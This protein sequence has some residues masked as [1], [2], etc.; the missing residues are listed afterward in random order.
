MKRIG[1]I[2]D[3]NLPT[4]DNSVKEK[5]FDWALS[6]A[7]RQ[8]LDCII[9]AG[10]LT[11]C[12]SAAAAE[13]VWKKLENC[14][15]PFALTLGNADLRDSSEREKARTFLKT[16]ND[17]PG[18]CL[19][20]T[21]RR[22]LSPADTA[23]LRNIAPGT[24]VVTHCPQECLPSETQELFRQ[25]LTSGR[26]ALLISGHF[27]ID[28]QEGNCHLIRGLDPD[29]AAGSPPALAIFTN[30]N[31]KWERENHACPVADPDKWSDE[32][33]QEFLRY[34]GISGMSS[35]LKNLELATEQNI[36]VFEFRFNEANDCSRSQLAQGVRNWREHGGHTLSAALPVC[37]WRNGELLGRGRMQRAIAL[38]LE[39]GCDRVRI[40]MPEISL[41]DLADKGNREKLSDYLREMYLPLTE[42]HC[43]IAFDNPHMP[44]R[45]WADENRQ[46][47]CLPLECIQWCNFMRRI[48]N[49]NDI[50]L[51]LDIGNA[52][53]NS[54]FSNRFTLSQWYQITGSVCTGYTLHQIMRDNQN[55]PMCGNFPLTTF[56]GRLISL[57]SFCMAWQQNTLHHAPMILEIK[58]NQ[59]IASYD[60]LKTE[61]WN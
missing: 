47:G 34:L 44:Y 59:G 15:L 45:K 6:E 17:L 39:M 11:A 35:P 31:G 48:L 56:Y 46:F 49:Y 28:R 58:E 18:V 50:G 27:H 53:N 38:A 7:M 19:L 20:D 21:S 57:S 3:S 10:D 40:K 52:R 5:V 42:H 26:I 30:K 25:L 32:S 29:K 24:V 61:L 1:V 23:K 14:R 13:R 9:G 2:S 36:G 55:E 8:N 60:A 54:P 4:E 12:G 22:E 41:K 51:Q 16:S 37:T 33:K 43:R